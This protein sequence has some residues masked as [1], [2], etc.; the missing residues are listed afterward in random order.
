MRQA[1]V[2]KRCFVQM[3]GY[4]PVSPE[5]Q[6][7]RFSREISRFQE[8]WN[9][10]AKVSPLRLSADGAVASWTAD[11]SGP[12]W[13][14]ATE[15]RYFRWDDFV[16]ADMKESDWWR[17]PLGT[18]ALLEFIATG[19]RDK[20]LR[21]GMAIWLLLCPSDP[22]FLG[23]LWL[24]IFFARNVVYHSDLPYS[25]VWSPPLAFA[26]FIVLRLTF[27]RMLFNAY[28][29]EP[30]VAL[31]IPAIGKPI[32]KIIRIPEMLRRATYRRLH[33]NFL[34]VHRQATMG[35]RRYSPAR[36]H[37]GQIQP[38]RPRRHQRSAAVL[39]YNIG[40]KE[41][42]A[43]SCVRRGYYLGCNA[44]PTLSRSWSS[45]TRRSR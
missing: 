40:D 34:R 18:A 32:I 26:F 43:A 11:T 28:N 3:I 17:F 8:T 25:S 45:S 29:V 22:L 44:S 10:Q 20:I 1:R 38:P 23:M 42:T 4:E 30:V 14:V 36:G 7:R 39:L 16:S 9:V 19:Y 33:L 2:R 35:K 31:R 27:G 6:H 37:R 13:R 5:H 21:H 15:Y 41:L 24:S 12:N